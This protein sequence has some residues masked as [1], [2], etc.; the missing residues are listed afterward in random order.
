MTESERILKEACAIAENLYWQDFFDKIDKEPDIK[1]PEGQFEKVLRTINRQ[2]VC[3]NTKPNKTKERFSFN[4]RLKA[5]LVAVIIILLLAITAMAITPLRNMIIKVYKDCTEIVFNLQDKNDYLYAKY[6]FVPKGYELISDLREKNSH[7][8]LFTNGHY[9]ICIDT[10][11]NKKSVTVIDTENAETSEI[12]V[13]DMQGYYSITE[14]KI[15]LI[16]STGKYN[17]C[18]SADPIDEIT[19]ETLVKIAQSR[20]AIN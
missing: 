10:L 3:K 7:F 19:I 5:V 16:W 4:N 8:M 12:M 1:I 17:H 20:R 13:G 14:K 11:M 18:I 2:P 9:D 6:E 15:I